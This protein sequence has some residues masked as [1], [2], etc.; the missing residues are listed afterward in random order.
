MTD[1]QLIVLAVLSALE[2]I[3]LL[4]ALAIALYHIQAA[5]DGINVHASKILWGV[6]AI[7]HEPAIAGRFAGSP[8]DAD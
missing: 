4:V 6:R 5:L 3:V 1:D 2:L 8:R 7:E